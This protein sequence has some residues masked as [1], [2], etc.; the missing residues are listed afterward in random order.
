MAIRPKNYSPYADVCA[1]ALSVLTGSVL[2]VGAGV[3]TFAQDNT[4]SA[5]A[6]QLQ[7]Y[8]APDQSASAGVPQGWKVARGDQTVI[9]ITGPQGE[10]I[11]LGSTAIARNTA[12][13]L[14]QRSSG[15]IDISMPYSATLAQKLTLIIENGAAVQ[16]KQPP[17]M[18]ITSATPLQLPPVLGQ[19]GRFLGSFTG[20]QGAMKF[21]AAMCSLPL[22]SAGF[23]K[24]IILMAQAPAAIAA[25]DAPIAI[26]V[27]RSYR[28]PPAMLQRKL[29]LFTPA[30]IIL[31]SIGG[32]RAP[33][34][35]GSFQVPDDT[36]SECFDL[37]VIRETPKYQLPQKCGG[38]KPD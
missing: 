22:D 2:M 37:V 28:I 4:A 18:S 21:V 20:D 1:A 36:G 23:Y 3:Q 35:R 38:T 29:A 5:P 25:Q 26:A 17:Q 16:G 13:Q 34:G 31:P 32:G 8:T 12:F 30:P 6:I 33:A 19:C 24:N 27:F 14:G 7:P 15:G 10:T 9:Q 11:F